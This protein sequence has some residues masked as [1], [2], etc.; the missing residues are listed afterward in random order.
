MY[1][2]L[3]TPVYRETLHSRQTYDSALDVN[4]TPDDALRRE[5]RVTHGDAVV[6]GKAQYVD[7]IPEE[8][9]I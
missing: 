6:C 4:Q 2:N 8:K 1:N 9:G 3:L 5:K 7:D